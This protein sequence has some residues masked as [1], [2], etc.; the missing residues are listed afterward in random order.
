MGG[1][2][3]QM[4]GGALAFSAYFRAAGSLSVL[5]IITVSVELYIALNYS[6]KGSSE[7]HPG[8]LWGEASVTVKVKIAFLQ[9][10][11]QRRDRARI[12]RLRSDLQGHADAER[13][14][15]LLRG[16]CGLSRL[17]G[18]AHG[19]ADDCLHCPAERP[20]DG[21]CAPDVGAHRTAAVEQRHQR[22][23]VAAFAVSRSARM[24]GDAHRRELERHVRWT[25]TGRS[26]HRERGAACGSVGRAIQDRH[27]CRAIPLRGSLRH[28]DRDDRQ[29]GNPRHVVDD[30]CARRDR[31]WLRRGKDL[32][33]VET[34][35]GDSDLRDIA[36]ATVPAKLPEPGPKP[37]PLDLGVETSIPTTVVCS[38]V[39]LP[40]SSGL[41]T[42]PWRLFG[43]TGTTERATVLRNGLERP[44]VRRSPLRHRAAYSTPAGAR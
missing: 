37:P 6:T 23:Q 15:R 21:R 26:D 27:R 22:R 25:A 38:M 31:T 33:S 16:I 20:R 10:V 13:L 1:V 34:L 8:H 40:C 44:R 42:R 30:L 14:E 39:T 41:A 3:Y 35:A 4:S 7:P 19:K 29:H 2:Y 11:R 36:R 9:Q 28:R 17:T 5:G 24:A 12:R 18:G 32:P 43:F